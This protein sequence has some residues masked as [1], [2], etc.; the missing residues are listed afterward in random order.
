MFLTRVYGS[1][2]RWPRSL[3]GCD[4]TDER[5]TPGADA[6]PTGES[7]PNAEPQNTAVQYPVMQKAVMSN[8]E[9][10]T[11]EELMATGKIGAEFAGRLLRLDR[12]E[13]LRVVALVRPLCAADSEAVATG[14]LATQTARGARRAGQ[15]AAMRAVVA[16]AFRAIDPI[17]DAV[18]GVRL[19]NHP[20]AVG[21]VVVET[22]AAG[23]LALCR[24]GS[25]HAVMEDQPIELHR[26]VET[27]PAEEEP[28]ENP[29]SGS[30]G[31]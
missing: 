11:Y 22:T 24:L 5:K 19:T 21:H 7:V 25:V 17:L 23:I 20:N 6:H 16:D 3:D 29:R 31:G 13:T 2:L 4:G 28:N 8:K 1:G 26:P 30:V 15:A 14:E 18:G 27:G 9:R 10:P 12:D